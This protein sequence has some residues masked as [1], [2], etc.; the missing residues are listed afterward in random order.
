MLFAAIGG[1]HGNVGALEA[2]LSRIDSDGIHTAL[3]TGNI[4]VGGEE[5]NAVI[6]RLRARRVICVQGDLDR[7]AVRAGRKAT[8]LRKRLSDEVYDAVLCAHETLTS[9]N[10]EYL[11]SL[12][13]RLTLTFEDK[14]VFVCHGTA[15]SQS[16]A[17]CADD[18]LDRF[19]RQREAANTDVVVCGSDEAAFTRVVDET[20]F[21]NPGRLEAAKDAV[22][23]VIVNTD[24]HPSSAEIVRA[25][26]R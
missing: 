3:C 12:P 16:G 23:L 11:R 18:P 17:L 10:L 20:L 21:V 15:T 1:V 19:R 2:A 6:E 24:N 7:L 22:S 14:S 9:D 13:R 25:I 4:A 5:A 26:H 8:P